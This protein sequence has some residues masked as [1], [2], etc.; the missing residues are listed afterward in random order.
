MS[1]T[2]PKPARQGRSPA[3]PAI[4]LQSALARAEDFRKQEGRHSAP[5]TS[6]Y[7]AWGLSEKGNTGRQTAAALRYFG[8]IEYEGRGSDRQI[9]L[10]SQALQ[11]LLDKRPE[12]SE[13]DEL[14]RQAALAPTIFS[15]MWKEWGPNLPSEATIQ[16]FL[17]KDQGFSESA[18]PE[19]ISCYKNTLSFAKLNEPDI[20]STHDDNFEDDNK[21]RPKVGDLIQWE[22]DGEL[23]L[24]V[25]HR[26]RA[27]QEHDGREWVFVEHSETGIP[28]EQT[29]VTEKGVSS[30]GKENTKPPV[31]PLDE[32]PQPGVWKEV[33][34][35]DDGDVVLTLPEKLSPESYHD[36]KA[37]MDM[38]IGKA[39]R[40][41]GV[42]D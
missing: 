34:D 29:K 8:L 1:N 31:L 2:D 13:R 11:I 5:P 3:Y 20:M 33:T 9:R 12:S 41:A 39:K 19:V 24:Q 14:V 38:I 4:S 7:K 26:V 37:W 23:K 40:R 30:G 32:L 22:V 35:L 16:T 17:L 21:D 18:A 15:E 27:I 6:A 42:K 28:M 36:L 25:P 10:T